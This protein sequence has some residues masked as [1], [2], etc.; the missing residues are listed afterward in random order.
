[1][2]GAERVRRYRLKHATTKPAP[3]TD[4]TA[5]L[6]QELAQAH[7]RITELERRGKGQLTRSRCEESSP[8]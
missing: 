7:K 5:A 1:M 4:S 2:T 3:K 8:S 6:K